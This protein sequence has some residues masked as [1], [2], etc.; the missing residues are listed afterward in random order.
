MESYQL[1]QQLLSKRIHINPEISAGGAT[2]LFISNALGQW[3]IFKE[4]N[5]VKV[6]AIVKCIGEQAGWHQKNSTTR[7]KICLMFL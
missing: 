4:I 1:R 7:I 6:P 3:F 2:L 5:A